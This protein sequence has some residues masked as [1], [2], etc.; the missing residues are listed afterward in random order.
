MWWSRRVPQSFLGR[1]STVY[2]IRTRP[3]KQITSKPGHRLSW[4]ASKSGKLI[5]TVS[6]LQSLQY[7]THP[8]HHEHTIWYAYSFSLVF[9]IAAGPV[10]P[11]EKARGKRVHF[12]KHILNAYFFARACP[13]N[14]IFVL[15]RDNNRR[16]IKL[17]KRVIITR[18]VVVLH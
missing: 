4:E 16:F 6:A 12:G 2:G 13:G 11:A 1:F 3:R 8:P 15:I 5:F 7:I 9:P 18:K 17:E 14:R 10:V